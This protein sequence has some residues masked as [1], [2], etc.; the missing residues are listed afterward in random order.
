MDERAGL[1]ESL[2]A[3]CVGVVFALVMLLRPG[4]TSIADR[5]AKREPPQGHDQVEIQRVS[6]SE[7]P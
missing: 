5:G 3:R 2:S 4:I 6:S 1:D 7:T